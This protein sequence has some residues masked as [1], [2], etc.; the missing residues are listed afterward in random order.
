MTIIRQTLEGTTEI[1]AFLG[2]PMKHRTTI[3]R[4]IETEGLPAFQLAGR[5]YADPDELAS[6]WRKKAARL[7]PSTLAG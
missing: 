1:A 6:W 2:L 3:T 7:R 4:W 5:W